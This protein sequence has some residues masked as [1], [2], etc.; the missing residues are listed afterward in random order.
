M[1]NIL[2][3]AQLNKEPKKIG[4]Y[5]A[6]V[7]NIGYFM[8]VITVGYFPLTEFGTDDFWHPRD[9][10]SLQ[11]CRLQNGMWGKLWDVKGKKT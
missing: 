11:G 3:Y 7:C 5:V 6:L 2:T 1:Q 9:E 8:F 4:H 10:A